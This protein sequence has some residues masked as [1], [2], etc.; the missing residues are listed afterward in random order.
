VSQNLSINV[1]VI[2]GDRIAELVRYAAAFYPEKLRGEENLCVPM[3]T[4]SPYPG[5]VVLELVPTPLLL[6]LGQ[7][8][9]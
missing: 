1:R 6:A 7:C 2:G 4:C 9:N 5:D 8:P 3:Q